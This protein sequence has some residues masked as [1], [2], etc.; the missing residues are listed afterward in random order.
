MADEAR[1]REVLDL[2]EMAQAAVNTPDHEARAAA[3]LAVSGEVGAAVEC[4][5]A[6]DPPAALRLAG[7]SSMFWQDAGGVDEGRRVVDLA[8]SAASAEPTPALGRTLLTASDL[9]FR[10]GD[11]AT[12]ETRAT[13]AIQVAGQ[14]ED[15]STA[16]IAYANLARI[17]FRNGD[18][19]EI[20]RHARQALQVAGDDAMGRRD[21]LHMLAWA[22]HT[23]GDLPE[24]RRRFESSLAFRRTLGDRFA[25]AVEL[26]N[27][28][29][30]SATEG[31][32]PAA[33][34]QLAE[35]L[36][37]GDELGSRYLAVNL[38]PSFAGL[39][40]SAGDDESG[41]RLLAAAETAAHSSGLVADPGGY[42]A[43]AEGSLRVRVEPDRF[44]QLF[45]EGAE[46]P[47]DESIELALRI[48]RSITGSAARSAS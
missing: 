5:A 14:V 46:L 36:T 39:A 40:E 11:Q 33:A 26:S 21:A 3:L 15:R 13:Q 23:A 8:I 29:D 24:A 43:G 41:V 30:L 19:P 1:A 37:I 25:I 27:L 45:E 4:L 7:S 22:A 18:A 34:E 32:L 42:G 10:Q 35:A 28:G 48:A 12:A 16:A 17:A 38:L 6:I 47:L 31:D 2:A 20:E 9:A 44:A